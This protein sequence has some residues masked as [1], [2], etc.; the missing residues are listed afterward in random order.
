MAIFNNSNR[1]D[2]P[3]EKSKDELILDKLGQR[4]IGHQKFVTHALRKVVDAALCVNNKVLIQ[5]YDH[6]KASSA[7]WCLL[8]RR[9][10]RLLYRF[11]N[12]RSGPANPVGQMAKHP[13][14]P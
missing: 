7:W 9:Q 10:R 12:P 1:D 11:P 6:V 3:F 13:E 2:K 14:R 4:V 5:H 8:G